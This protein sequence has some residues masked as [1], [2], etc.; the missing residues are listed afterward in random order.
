MVVM[1][2]KEKQGLYISKSGLKYRGWTDKAIS[3][4]L[5]THDK[6][7]KNPHYSKSSP[8]R[9]YLTLRVEEIEKS[10]E[11]KQFI[12][13][14][15]SRVNGAS[16]AVSTKKN[17]L[18]NEV[19]GWDISLKYKP[20]EV[21][22]QDAIRSYNSFHEDLLIER[23]HNYT[24]AS[25]SSNTEFLNRITVNHIRHNLSYY[26]EKLERLF[27]K[28][29]KMEAYIILNKKIYAKIG[30]MHPALAAECKRQLDRKMGE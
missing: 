28:V 5:P 20:V 19:L 8:M 12:D 30:D 22:I 4:F 27:G 10:R 21:V 11:Y 9:L 16:K 13:G 23:G 24:D 3:T 25:P 2:L 29:G 17:R 26:D 6:E 15:K 18:L 1:E 14:N 7:A